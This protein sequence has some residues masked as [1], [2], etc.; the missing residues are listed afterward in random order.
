MFSGGP[1]GRR[2]FR[3]RPVNLL[4]IALRLIHILLG[5]FWVGAAMFM[6]FFLAPSVNAVG[7]DGAKVM[8]HLNVKGKSHAFIG[9]SAT[10]TLLSGFLL[11]GYFIHTSPGW[12]ASGQGMVFGLGGLLAVGAWVIGLV[13]LRPASMRIGELGAAMAMAGGPPMATQIS[14]MQALQAKVQKSSIVVA[15]HL[16]AAVA[17]MA[18][19]RYIY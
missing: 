15:A 19:A 11:Y 4:L 6:S 18:A 1:S 9:G 17:C 5:V 10:L 12:A 8:Q 14:E 3:E 2:Q 16:I 7:A 13:R